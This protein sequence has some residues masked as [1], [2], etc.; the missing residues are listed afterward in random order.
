MSRT[1]PDSADLMPE[2]LELLKRKNKAMKTREILAYMRSWIKK[3]GFDDR[4]RSINWALIIIG[5]KRKITLNTLGAALAD[6]R[7]KVGGTQALA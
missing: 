3:N 1:T 5:R 4:D 6:Q 7:E 2:V